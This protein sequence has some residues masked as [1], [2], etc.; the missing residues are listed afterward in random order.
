MELTKRDSRAVHRRVG[1]K[2]PAPGCP[3]GQTIRQFL[4]LFQDAELVASGEKGL[5]MGCSIF[6]VGVISKIGKIADAEDE[7][8]YPEATTFG[9]VR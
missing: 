6:G 8:H 5:K 9:I 7:S 4:K 2:S 3:Y 1:E